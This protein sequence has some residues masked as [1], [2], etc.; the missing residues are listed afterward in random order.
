MSDKWEPIATAPRDGTR[1]LVSDTYGGVWIAQFS[2]NAAFA[3]FECGLGWQVFDCED[4]WS[5]IAFTDDELVC[6]TALP[7]SPVK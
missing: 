5:S 1:I 7:E 4:G 6:W 2:P 3:R